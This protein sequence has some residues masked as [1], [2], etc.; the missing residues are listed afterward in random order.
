MNLEELENMLTKFWE[1]IFRK[2][3]RPIQPVEIARALVREMAAH[4]D[5][6]KRQ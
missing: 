6:Y 1:G 3:K 4:R 5:V 2:G